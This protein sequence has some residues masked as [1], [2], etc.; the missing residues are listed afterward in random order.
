[1][2]SQ[3]RLPRWKSVLKFQRKVL[4][5]SSCGLQLCWPL[6]RWLQAGCPAH[7][8]ENE[9]GQAGAPPPGLGCRLAARG[10]NT[11]RPVPSSL[12][13]GAGLSHRHVP[14]FCCTWPHLG[15]IEGL[16]YILLLPLSWTLNLFSQTTPFLFY[17]SQ[18]TSANPRRSNSNI[19][20]PAPHK[21]NLKE[22]LLIQVMSSHYQTVTVGQ[23]TF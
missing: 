14:G 17:F 18:I 4:P 15:K 16:G 8:T 6:S 3:E 11:K 9:W 1:M 21:S 19:L 23:K 22:T 7:A 10:R 20:P 2:R 12:I 5:K 13:S